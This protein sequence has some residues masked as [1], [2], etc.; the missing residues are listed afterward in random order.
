MTLAAL[1]WLKGHDPESTLRA[2][3]YT[4]AYFPEEDPIGTPIMAEITSDLNGIGRHY[5]EA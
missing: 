5:W 4:Q 3:G 2:Q 1:R